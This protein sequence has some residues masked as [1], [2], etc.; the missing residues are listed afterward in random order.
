MRDFIRLG[1][2]AE[3]DNPYLTMNYLN[4]SEEILLL[5]SIFDKGF[6][7]RGLKVNWCFDCKSALAE[8]EV[9]YHNKVD[10]AIEV[11]LNAMN[12]IRNKLK[13]SLI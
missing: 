1:V 13:N 10:S 5:K 11:L 9:E 6:I 4:E 2:L 12:E 8:A 3:W 7:Y